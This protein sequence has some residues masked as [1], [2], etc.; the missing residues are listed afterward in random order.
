MELFKLRLT[1]KHFEIVL[2]VCEKDHASMA[3][4]RKPACL[5]IGNEKWFL[6]LICLGYILA[7]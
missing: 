2:I 1:V 5:R 6:S 4:P 7:N 3:A